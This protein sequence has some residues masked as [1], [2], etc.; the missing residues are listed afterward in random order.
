MMAMLAVPFRLR[1]SNLRMLPNPTVDK[2]AGPTLTIEFSEEMVE[3]QNNF[4]DAAKSVI[5]LG[6]SQPQ[7][8]LLKTIT[9]QWVKMKD[10]WSD[11]IDIDMRE[12]I[13]DALDQID[14]ALADREEFSLAEIQSVMASHLTAVLAATDDLQ[15]W[16]SANPTAKSKFAKFYID[17]ILSEVKDDPNRPASPEETK[18]KRGVIWLAL[19]FR[20][21]CWFLLHDFNKSDVNMMAAD[22][23]GSRMPVF[24]G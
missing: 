10:V 24:I 8:G 7:H 19:M 13:H 11:K 14:A 21:I 22:M 6:V 1:G 9:D 3:F 5:A 18:S 2:W 17:K 20:M 12:R 16:I 15:S 4:A 23:K